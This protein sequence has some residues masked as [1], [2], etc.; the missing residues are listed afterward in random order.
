MKITLTKGKYTVYGGDGKVI[1]IS[2]DKGI[3]IAYAKQ[4]KGVLTYD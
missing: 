1:I 2:T 3:C 4:T